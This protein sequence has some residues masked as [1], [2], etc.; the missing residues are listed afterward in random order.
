LTS[1]VAAAAAGASFDAALLA[2]GPSPVE[3]NPSP[4]GQARLYS[5]TEA[6]FAA[7][8][9]S[10][11]RLGLTVRNDGGLGT[12]LAS[13]APSLEFPLGS[14][15]EH[16]VRAGLW[17]GGVDAH[18][19]TLVSTAATSRGFGTEFVPLTGI[20]ERSNLPGSPHYSAD[21]RSEQ[22]FVYSFTD[23]APSSA[24][25]GDHHPLSVQID[26]E[27]LL[28]SFE[29]FDAI[30]IL[31]CDIINLSATDP[32][33][34][35]YAGLFVE[36]ASG[37]KDPTDP[38]WSRDW[39][40]QKDIGFV[41]SLR[42]VTE[43]HFR[44]DGGRAPTWAGVQL[45]G[46]RP[47][48]ASEMTVSFHWWDQADEIHGA[49]EAPTSDAE[50]Y[51]AMSS[52]QVRPTHGSEAPHHDPVA[53]FSIGPFPVV[54]PGDTVT[55]SF[56]WLGGEDH[57]R[58]GRTASEDLAF[59]AAAALA[60]FETDFDIPTPPPSPDLFV[61]SDRNRLTL[62]WT[63]DPERFVDPQTGEIDFQGYRIYVGEDGRQGRFYNIL[64]AD[65]V[66]S[67]FYDTGL[68][69]LVEDAVVDGVSYKYRYDTTG[70]RD[71]FEYWVAVTSFDTGSSGAG[72]SGG[73]PSLESGLT[74]N[75]S[76]AIPGTP[77]SPAG[78]PEVVV[79][80]NPY[81][82]DA[83]WDGEFR[84]DRYLWFANL[85]ARCTIRI[86]TLAGDL[87]DTIHFDQDYAPT[88]VSG[89]HPAHI[90]NAQLPSLSGGMAAWDLVSRNGD[91]IASG[92]YMFSVEDSDTGDRQI[93]KF[94]VVK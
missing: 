79:F 93:G 89:L 59:R 53:L 66:D 67:I 75:L 21:A 46:T 1:L 50:R 94:L 42:M 10:G 76:L 38:N 2:A 5:G 87:V 28:H 4:P 65:I 77:A 43:H 71:G 35:L 33:H 70:L 85:P 20:T 13:R 37:F 60:A 57:A 49:G 32:I 19:D 40:G 80:P 47:R 63:D 14:G 81:R 36:L 45:L 84:R 25:A 74:Q 86:Y 82:G 9:S 12:G 64:E 92:L 34:D 6:G 51:R 15:I 8:T 69:A 55:V 22:D 26:S 39:F 52:G 44:L 30:V 41:D 83:A 27:T 3:V 58:S 29:P 18:G 56:A 62:R 78:G 68:E 73:L 91:G 17:V 54:E 16:L 88:D 48:P 11:N 31:N 24:D 7:R 61:Q 23:T 72:E 90:A